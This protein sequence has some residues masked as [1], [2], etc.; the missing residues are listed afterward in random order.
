MQISRRRRLT[1]FLRHANDLLDPDPLRSVPQGY[2]HRRSAQQAD[3]TALDLSHSNA[4]LEGLNGLFQAARTRARGYRPVTT[5][6]TII[7][8]IAAPLG[9]LYLYPLEASSQRFSMR[10]SR[11]R[12]PFV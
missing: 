11:V 4:R 9:D 12:C 6:A 3:P 10:M 7:Y 8:L 1:N 2:R 5:F